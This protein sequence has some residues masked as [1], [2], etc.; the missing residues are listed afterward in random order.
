MENEFELLNNLCKC[1]KEHLQ[2]QEEKKNEDT[3]EPLPHSVM[4][5]VGEGFLNAPD[6][7]V[8][9]KEAL[10]AEGGMIPDSQL[11]GTPFKRETID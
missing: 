6:D 3:V 7:I 9:L 8:K 1:H 4:E 10:E 2:A 11:N 5:K